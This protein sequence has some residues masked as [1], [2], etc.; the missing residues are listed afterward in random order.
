MKYL[1]VVLAQ[2]AHT[3]ALDSAF[4]KA[5]VLCR[6]AKSA[7]ADIVLFPEMWSNGYKFFDPDDPADYQ[8]WKDSAIHEDDE[9]LVSIGHLAK[10]LDMAIAITYLRKTGEKP[11]NSMVLFDRFGVQRLLYTKVHVCA[12]ELE[13]Y[14]EPGQSF[15]VVNLNTSQGDVRVGSMICFDREFPESARVLGLKGAEVILVPNACYL[16]EH[17]MA[18]FKTR[19]FENKAALAM[20]N[21]PAPFNNGQSTAID[22]V[23]FDE[24]GN[25]LDPILGLAGVDEE[26]LIAKLDIGRLREYRSSAIWD[27]RF[28][29]PDTYGILGTFANLP[30][31][32]AFDARINGNLCAPEIK[33]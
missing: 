24:Q 7:M 12:H 29:Q 3:G 30:D 11:G 27:P 25:S 4:D 28:R 18:Q 14:C 1:T 17:R 10:E 22:G 6:K 19:A 32:E 15:P 21:Y 5:H 16:D 26:I 20:A 9:P 33:S 13:K 2:A 8:S 23:F 31:S